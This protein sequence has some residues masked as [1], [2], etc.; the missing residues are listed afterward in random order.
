M[1]QQVFDKLTYKPISGG[2]R[3]N[4]T[5]EVTTNPKKH[6][7][8]YFSGIQKESLHKKGNGK[9]NNLSKVKPFKKTPTALNEKYYV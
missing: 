8:A 4:Q 5:N 7:N 9:P 2:Y 6:R 3:C 1:E